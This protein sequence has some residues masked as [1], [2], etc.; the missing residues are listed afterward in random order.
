V[1]CGVSIRSRP[2]QST[3]YRCTAIRLTEDADET[4]ATLHGGAASTAAASTAEHGD[5]ADGSAAVRTNG[6]AEL[7]IEVAVANE[8]LAY[9]QCWW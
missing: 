8:L 3:L 4:A 2:S 1:S 9:D 5:A 7:V 6:E